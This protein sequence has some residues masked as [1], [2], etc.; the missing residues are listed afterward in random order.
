MHKKSKNTKKSTQNKVKKT[1]KQK[2]PIIKSYS[3]TIITNL[4]VLNEE[5]QHKSWNN[6]RKFAE[7]GIKFYRDN[8]ENKPCDA[9]LARKLNQIEAYCKLNYCYD[10]IEHILRS[11]QTQ[12]D[13]LRQIYSYA[14]LINRNVS[15]V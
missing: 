5:E 7:S 11:R 1:K 14:N 2:T 12:I 9:E 6:I 3:R 13:K 8:H 4:P 15:F 10:Q